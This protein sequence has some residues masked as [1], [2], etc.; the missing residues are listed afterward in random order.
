MT[1][2]QRIDSVNGAIKTM[3]GALTEIQPPEWVTV[4][5][6]AMGFWRSITQARSADRW[7]NADL[8]AAAELARTKAKIEQLN[9]E[10]EA[11]G[12]IVVNER[13][14]PI[15][16]PRHSLLE[17]LSR[18]MVALSRAL[19]VHAEATQGKSR[20]QVKGNKAQEKARNAVKQDDDD[21]IS[22]PTH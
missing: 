21:L 19:Q 7:N 1:K 3:E 10:I 5:E 8:E 9:K 17:T 13:G 15:V 4:P 18:R 11:E 20:E 6:S 12:D 16:N 22:R 14:T 2:K